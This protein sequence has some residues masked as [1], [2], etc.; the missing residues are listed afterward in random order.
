MI[1]AFNGH[2]RIRSDN[3]QD[4]KYEKFLL[5]K[6]YRKELLNRATYTSVK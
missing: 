3:E 2:I 5:L 4:F 1:A 6:L